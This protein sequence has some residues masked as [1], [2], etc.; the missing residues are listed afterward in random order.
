MISSE[1]AAHDVVPVEEVDALLATHPFADNKYIA[2]EMHLSYRRRLTKVAPSLPVAERL[3]DEV[4]RAGP[5]AE[6]RVF[7][8]TIVRC[9]I[10]HAQKQIEIG[11]TY[12][13]PLKQCEEIFE[14]TIRLLKLKL[15][16]N[17]PLGSGLGDRFGSDAYC[18]W[19]WRRDRHDDVFSR[20]LET[21]VH[22]NFGEELHTLSADELLTFL[23][24]V[25]L[26]NKL[27]PQ[28]SRGAL[29][30][31]HLIVFFAAFS[32]TTP[33]SSSEY[34]LSGS[35]YLSRKLLG[36]PW[37]IAEHLFHEAL[38][39]QLYD[40][41][42]GHSLLAPN[43]QRED[44]PR[45]CSL[46]NVPDASR[47]NHW[48][49]HRAIAAFHVY[50]N[51]A[52]M[53]TIA[54]RQT[55][56]E[57]NRLLAEYGPNRMVGSRTAC[58]RAQYLLEQIRLP[59][60]WAELGAAGK[61]LVD[62][63]DSVLQAIDPSPPSPGS[64]VHLLIDRYWREARE[65]EILLRGAPP[66]CTLLDELKE[67]A[68]IEANDARSVLQAISEIDVGKYDSDLAALS[69]EP[70]M[71]F[72]SIRDLVVKF[73]PNGYSLS[74]TKMPDEMMRDLIERSSERLR[75]ILKR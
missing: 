56:E 4:S 3:L 22:E 42:A 59:L 7:G 20:S 15:G 40:F 68:K 9:A 27:L 1:S 45:I 73:L 12:G 43:A 71:E 23:K 2:H 35:I 52:L 49:I 37:W 54:E 24:G 69:T 17:A 64:Y 50:V 75:T 10:Q 32:G 8:D 61:R 5:D 39:Q 25:E 72:V 13:L 58:A 18:G 6:Y 66:S 34:R 21:L 55:A 74:E 44:A 26:L 70:N 63:F 57:D 33:S 19:I 16:G 36:S 38:H 29:S 47:G 51:L 30:H 11:V 60:H 31:V 53:A 28:S 67:L 48:D 65:V 62:W 14:E 41:R 46:W